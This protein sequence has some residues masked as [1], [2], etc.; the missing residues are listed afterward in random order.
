MS[1]KLRD[2]LNMHVKVKAS[3]HTGKSPA[4]QKRR[5][6]FHCVKFTT[7]CLA[8]GWL[9]S[10]PMTACRCSPIAN[11]VLRDLPVSII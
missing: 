11:L 8:T 5:E 2:R 4:E 3:F 7:I 9:A 10:L 6:S 1:S